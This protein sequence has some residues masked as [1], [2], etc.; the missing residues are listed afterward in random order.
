MVMDTRRRFHSWVIAFLIPLLAIGLSAC[1]GAGGTGA[2][3]GIDDFCTRSLVN[4]HVPGLAAGIIKGGKLV[5]AGGYGYANL[6]AQRPVT[7]DTVFHLASVSKTILAT[8]VMQQVE[9]GKVDLDADVNTY[10]P[11]SARSPHAPGTPI[12]MR[13]LLSH[14]SSIRDNW[15]VIDPYYVLGDSPI[16]L[17]DYLNN[18]LVPGGTHFS[19]T[20]NFLSTPP[21]QAYEYSNIGASLAAFIVE[22]VTN[23]PFHQLCKDRV[24]KP[25]GMN[26][27]SWRL[28]DLDPEHLAMPYAWSTQGYKPFGAYGKPNYPAGCL[29]S[30]VGE[31]SKHLIMFMQGGTL[32]DTRLLEPSTAKAMLTP[33]CPA[34]DPTQGLIWYS[35]RRDDAIYW[36]HT[37]SDN[38]VCTVIRFRPADGV[39][40]IVLMNGDPLTDG[41]ILELRA[42]IE[43]RLFREAGNW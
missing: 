18:Y 9:A 11:F 19:A 5:W 31:L 27:T 36:G 8:A 41:S 16:P 26:E 29:H 21:G 20:K 28:A 4:A 39:G 1:G 40:V 30:S 37:G 24:M 42:S 2:E 32:E 15:G 10:L 17:G 7:P 38:G 35:E 25:L 3:A 12:T 43:A 23:T 33:Q 22:S 14:T 34:L 6:E 13:M